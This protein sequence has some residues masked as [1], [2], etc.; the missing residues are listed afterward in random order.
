MDLAGKKKALSEGYWGEEG[1]AWSPDGSEVFFSGGNAYNNFKV[2]AVSLD[3]RRRI[4]A[5]SAGGL[6]ILD[7]APD[8]RWIASRDD[9]FRDMPVQAPGETTEKDLSWLDLSAAGRC[10]RTGRRCSLP[11]RAAASA[12]ITRSVSAA[13]TGRRWCGSARGRPRICPLMES[14]RSRSYRRRRSNSFSIPRAPVRRAGS[15]A[16]VS[17]GT[18]PHNSSRTGERFSRA[19]TKR[20]ARYG[21]ISNRSTGALRVR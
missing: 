15:S 3:G 17:S 14:G 13:P 5:E 12:S 4:A 1:L 9:F 16:A 6:T 11:R 8:G 2:Y 10:H 21:V 18:T 20:G 19:G 7:V